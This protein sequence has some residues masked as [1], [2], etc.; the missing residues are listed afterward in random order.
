MGEPS[1]LK[2]Q[3][4]IILVDDDR[5]SLETLSK[6]LTEDGY[7]VVGCL[8]GKEALEKMKNKVYDI[9][10]TDLRMP[11][12][13]G[14]ELLKNIKKMDPNIS[15]IIITAFGEMDTYLEAIDSGAYDYIHKPINYEGL[16]KLLETVSRRK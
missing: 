4:E 15:V 16:L 13:G 7:K 14:I 8:N 2:A 5:Y 1:D 6:L 10:I 11:E 9:I 12:M 3:K